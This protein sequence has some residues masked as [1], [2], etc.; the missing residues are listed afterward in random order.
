MTAIVHENLSL[1][2][3]NTFSIDVATRYFTA[4]NSVNALQNILSDEQWKTIPCFILGGGSNILFTRNFEG[5][6]IHNQILGIEKIDETTDHVYLKIGAGENWHQLVLYCVEN[7]YAGIENLSLIPGTVGAA[8]IQNIGAYG[9]ELKDVL[10]EVHTLD[11]EKNISCVFNNADCQFGYR[12]SIFK[13]TLKNK[14][15]VTNVVLRL[16]KNPVFHVEYGAIKEKLNGAPLSIRAISDAVIHI[17]QEKLP[18]PKVIGNAGSFFKNP[19]VPE[20]L[21]LSLQEKYP[22]MP[23]FREENDCVKIPAGWLIEQ[24][25]FKGKRF[26][27][28]GVHA[29]QALVL[30]NYG[31]GTGREIKSLSEIIQ[32]AVSEKFNIALS[33]EVNIL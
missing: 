27:D 19:I 16:N 29:H 22:K 25:G 32:K 30:V 18:D 17:R 21:F 33:T 5:L 14:H 6:V 31:D 24:C 3:Y 23:Y 28:V 10:H 7:H 8:P 20:K 15:I 13:N 26:G 9:V 12:D 4:V 2:P 1:K 11:I